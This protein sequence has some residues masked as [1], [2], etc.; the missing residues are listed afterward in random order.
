MTHPLQ[1]HPL[2]VPL[3]PKQEKPAVV[4][5]EK[6]IKKRKYVKTGIPN[7]S[8]EIDKSASYFHSMK[9]N[10]PVKY[11]FILIHGKGNLK[12]GLTFFN[13]YWDRTQHHTGRVLDRVKR[14][15]VSESFQSASG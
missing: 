5:K 2:Y 6:A 9:A 4:V 8:E 11:R 7:Q 13:S 14:K 12:T 1:L 3:E 15:E 10:N